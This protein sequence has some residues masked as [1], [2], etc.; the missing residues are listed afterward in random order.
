MHRKKQLTKM[1]AALVNGHKTRLEMKMSEHEAAAAASL[2]RRLQE[3]S[4][5]ELSVFDQFS[6]SVLY[7]MKARDEGVKEHGN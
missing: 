3:L 4:L 1:A 6:A 2:A 7:G 5:S